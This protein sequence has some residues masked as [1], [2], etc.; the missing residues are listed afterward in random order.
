LGRNV[1]QLDRAQRRVRKIIRDLE[2][3][4]CR[5]G[6]DEHEEKIRQE[7]IAILFK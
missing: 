2:N 1:A 6:L 7:E 4:S 5:T 3:T